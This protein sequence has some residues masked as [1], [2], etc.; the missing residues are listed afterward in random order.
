[1]LPREIARIGYSSSISQS[2][3][4]IVARRL[5]TEMTRGRQSHFR[6]SIDLRDKV[7]TLRKRLKLSPIQFD[8][9][10]RKAGNSTT[11]I[12]KKAKQKEQS[13]K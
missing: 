13:T 1:M 8:D 9:V 10:V 7:R 11:A 3:A 5:D 12:S 6:S 4:V 2:L